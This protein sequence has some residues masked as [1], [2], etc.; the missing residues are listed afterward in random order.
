MQRRNELILNSAGE[1]ICG[2][3]LQGRA[4]FVNPAAAKITGWKVEEL[5]GKT[6]D[7]IFF[8]ARA[9]GQQGRGPGF[10]Q[11]RAGQLSS[12]ADVL[13]QGWLDFPVEYVRTPITE[14]NKMVG[15][16]VMFKD[17]TER[18]MVEDKL[19]HK[20]AELARSNGELE[21]FAFV[22]SHDLQEPLRKIQAFGDRLKIKCEAVN[23]T[24][25]AII[26][27]ACKAPPPGCRPSSTISSPFPASSALP[28]LSSTWT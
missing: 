7:A 22:A 27:S 16:V 25:A 14:N 3:D 26:W 15:A 18:R 5:I 20:A 13:P 8:P 4:T 1:G 23:L 28:S 10:A 11:G 21:Q 24:K 6:E 2:F 19:A 12:G 17:I 9:P